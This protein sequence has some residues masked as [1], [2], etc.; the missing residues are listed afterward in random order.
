[1]SDNTDYP[2][3][4]LSDFWLPFGIL[5]SLYCLTSDY[6]LYCIVW[7]LITLWYLVVIVLSDF[8]LPFVLYCL[9]SDY[10]L[11]SCGHCIVWLLI[12]LCI[13]LSDF[14][15]PLVSCGTKG[16]CIV[17]PSDYPL[18]CIV[19]LLITKGNQKVIVLSDFW[20]P[21]VSEVIDN[22]ILY[23]LYWLSDFWLPFGILCHCIVWLLITL[24]IVL[25]DFWLPLVIF[26]IVLSDLLITLCIVLSDFWLPFGILWSLYCL[27]SD[28]PLYCIVWLLITKGYCHWLSDFWLPFEILYWSLTSDYQRVIVLSDLLIT[29][30]IVLSDFWLPFGILWSLYCLTFWLPFVLYCLTSDYQRVIV[31]SDL[32][33]TLYCIVLTTRYYPLYWSQKIQYKGSEGQTFWLPKGYC[34]VWPSDYPLYCIV[35]LLITFGILWSLYCLTFWLSPFVLYCLTSDYQRVIVLS[36]LLITLCIVLSDFWLPKGNQKSENT[37]QIVLSDFWLPSQVLYCLTFW[38]PFVLYCLTL[39]IVL[40]DL[41]ITLCIVLSDFWL[42]YKG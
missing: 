2:L 1:M 34:I 26:V 41:L 32:L 17:W 20:L 10:P 21:F 11:V 39:G 40:S 31:L 37:I 36:D 3:Y 15:L 9:T 7:L 27:T 6:P 25:S 24:C 4:W 12:T 5:W 16:N 22:T 18:Y 19:W 23:P 33:I 38:L 28:Y 35:W 30:C 13:V 42:P 14:W 8:W 29:L